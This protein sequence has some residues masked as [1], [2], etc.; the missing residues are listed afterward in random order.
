MTD[1]SRT[2]DQKRSREEKHGKLKTD[3]DSQLTDA[4]KDS[5]PASDPVSVGQTSTKPTGRIDRRPPKI[6]KQSVDETAR[7][8]EKRRAG[9]K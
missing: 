7:R 4:L 1:G 3:L 5:F 8:L 9:Q 2:G 6:D